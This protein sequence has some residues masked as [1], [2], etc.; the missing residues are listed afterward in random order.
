V[1]S[2]LK[3]L[4]PFE[5]II[6]QD[7][8]K[9]ALIICAVDETL[10]GVLV[11]GPKG[12]GKTTIIR[13]L[14]AVLP[15]REIVDGCKYNCNPD[16]I[17]N[18]CLDCRKRLERDGALPRRLA[19]MEIVECPVGV[20][21]EGLLGFIDDEKSLKE[22]VR[23]FIPGILGRANRNI[24]YIDGINLLPDNIVNEILDPAAFGWSRVKREGFSVD[25][26]SRFTLVASMSPE[27]GELR[28]QILDRFALNVETTRINDPIMRQQIIKNNLMFEDDLERFN[29]KYKALN[30]R[31][32]ERIE[33]A[34][35]SISSV[36]VPERYLEVIAHSCSRLGVEGLRS[37]LSIMRASRALAAYKGKTRI[38]E[39]E[40]NETF[41]LA[42]SHRLRKKHPSK[43]RVLKVLS[44]EFKKT[45]LV[46]PEDALYESNWIDQLPDPSIHPSHKEKT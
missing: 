33:K 18:L 17:E 28:P 35:T 22:G 40:L 30:A 10:G 4:Y 13:S 29:A 3:V 45:K 37:D 8:V 7:Q 24:L 32:S 2:N 1:E 5:A 43:E 38:A 19:R 20:T 9:T 39:E 16:D 27:E 34:K 6:G 25:Y 36:E 15:F 44:E 12:S 26:P 41:D 11:S 46:N 31:L 21:E 14:E 23:A 42:V